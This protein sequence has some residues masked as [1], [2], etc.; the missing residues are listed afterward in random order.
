MLYIRDPSR[1][2]FTFLSV[3][4]L[5][6]LLHVVTMVESRSAKHLLELFGLMWMSW[7]GTPESL[8]IDPDTGFG[9]D[10]ANY[11]TQRGV[12]ICPCPAEAHWQRGRI[13]RHQGV[14]KHMAAKAIDACAIIGHDE[15]YMMAPEVSNAKNQLC[16]R[17]GYSPYMWTFGKEMNLRDSILADTRS[18]VAAA[19]LSDHQEVQR[20]MSVRTEAAKAALDYVRV[21][22]DCQAGD[23]STVSTLPRRL[24]ARPEGHP[25]TS[26]ALKL[27]AVLRVVP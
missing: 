25:R 9:G 15:M 14:W 19:N 1:T 18:A 17:A 23:S 11:F 5:S 12:D 8:Y 6:G 2:Q 3:L 16:R 13:E 7:A 27:R 24:R 20:R 21:P 22:H 26:T 10:F 4:G